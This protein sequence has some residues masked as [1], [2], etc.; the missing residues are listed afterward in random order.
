M[1]TSIARQSVIIKCNMQKSV[2]TGNYEYYYAAGLL[3]KLCGV[4]IDDNVK[5][6]E[7]LDFFLENI[8]K[9]TAKDEKETYLFQML[10]EYRPTEEYDEQMQ[11]LLLW[12]KKEQHLWTLT[13]PSGA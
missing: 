12:G 2:L 13:V 4:Q 3:E 7:L 5:P 10:Y 8:P 9:L 6:L 1:I 11:E